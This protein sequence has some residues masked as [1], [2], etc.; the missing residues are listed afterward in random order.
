MVID[1]TRRRLLAAGLLALA[2]NTGGAALFNAGKS[3]ND[4]AP[5][6][7]ALALLGAWRTD[8]TDYVGTWSAADGTRGSALPARCHGV[9]LDPFDSGTAIVVARRPG[10]YILRLDVRSLGSVVSR[11]VEMDRV[12]E[13]H[14]AFSADGKTL[15]TTESD[16]ASGQGLIGVRDAATLAKRAEFAS[17]G[18]GPHALLLEPE[19]DLLI[20][21]GG[22]LTLPETGRTKLNLDGMDPSLVR[23]DAAGG[24]LRGQWRLP[25][26]HLSIRHLARAENGRVGIALQAE[27]SKPDER[28]NAP[29]FALFDGTAL[30][31][32]DKQKGIELGGYGADVACLSNSAGAWFAVSC[33][34]AGLV[35]WWDNSGRCQGVVPM[36]EAGA[37]VRCDDTLIAAGEQGKLARV[38]PLGLMVLGSA[39]ASVRWDNHLSLLSG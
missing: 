18:M 31:V 17:H 21:N 2:S 29:L 10:Q 8:D 12:F 3:R 20:A 11:E 15:Y 32:G 4:S 37:L 27:H 7:A 14:A 26:S 22:I 6:F 38:T 13:G 1:D 25:D 30:Q 39:P 34:R 33:T 36:R 16:L 24:Q 28:A 9:V 5:Q 23:L 35:A 19:G